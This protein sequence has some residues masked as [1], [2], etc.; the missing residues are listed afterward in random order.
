MSSKIERAKRLTSSKT[1]E[2]LKSVKVAGFKELVKELQDIAKANQASQ[3]AITKSIDQLAKVVVM[4]GEESTD[5]SAV[6]A[7]IEELK[8][9][10]AKK[11]SAPSDYQID[12]TRDKRTGLMQSGIKLTAQP[13]RMH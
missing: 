8:E 4:A 5:F 7:A 3:A 10:V 11:V 1:S 2:V 6:I 12:F 13:K 9:Q